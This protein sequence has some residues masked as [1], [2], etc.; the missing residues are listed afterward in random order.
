MKLTRYRRSLLIEYHLS[1]YSI[2][3]FLNSRHSVGS[4]IKISDFKSWLKL[5]K[6]EIAQQKAF[7]SSVIEIS[8][9]NDTH[10]KTNQQNLSY[11][12]LKTSCSNKIMSL[13]NSRRNIWMINMILEVL[14]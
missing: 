10:Q 3:K 4:H 5:E 7:E 1:G 11:K 13:P 14:E 12:K 8:K 6:E 2:D 9:S